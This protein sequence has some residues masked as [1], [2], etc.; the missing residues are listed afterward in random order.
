M[1]RG[2][3]LRI[4]SGTAGGWRLVDEC[5]HFPVRLC[6]DKSDG[7]CSLKPELMP[8]VGIQPMQCLPAQLVKLMVK[9]L[10]GDLGRFHLVCPVKKWCLLS[11]RYW[12][13]GVL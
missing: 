13:G 7:I 12:S 5:N 9:L 3:G 10:A 4:N 1:R 11:R 6:D 2:A 8:T